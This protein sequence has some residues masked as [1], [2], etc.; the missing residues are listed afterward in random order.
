M[1]LLLVFLVSYCLS[2]F[3][4]RL[5]ASIAISSVLVIYWGLLILSARK[6]DTIGFA[7]FLPIMVAPV[8]AAMVVA[9]VIAGH[10]AA[11]DAERKKSEGE[12]ESMAAQAL[13]WLKNQ[14]IGVFALILVLMY[15]S[16]K[17]LFNV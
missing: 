10:Y 11:E 16:I 14:R 5:R 1:F 7:I 17:E 13:A 4:G 3:F 2:R 12:P 6:P 9:G 8:I 15:Y